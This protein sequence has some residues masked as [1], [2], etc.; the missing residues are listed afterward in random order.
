MTFLLFIGGIFAAI[1]F[2]LGVVATVICRRND[3]DNRPIPHAC[4]Y[5]HG[6][7]LVTQNSSNAA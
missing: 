6:E 7:C 3:G 5:P 2:F 4:A 1:G